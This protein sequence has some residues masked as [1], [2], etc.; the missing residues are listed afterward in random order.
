LIGGNRE[1]GMGNRSSQSESIP[2]MPTPLRRFPIPHSRFPKKKPVNQKPGGGILESL[3][4]DG[5]KREA[6]ATAAGVA[7]KSK[8]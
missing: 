1:W 8:R 2:G 6:A 4:I 5:L 7:L 3:V